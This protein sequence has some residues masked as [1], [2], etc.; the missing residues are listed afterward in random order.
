MKEWFIQIWNM[1][2]MLFLFTLRSLP[3]SCRARELCW[4]MRTRHIQL[5]TTK[6]ENYSACF[7]SIAW[8]LCVSFRSFVLSFA[9]IW[10]NVQ[11]TALYSAFCIYKCAT[12]PYWELNVFSP[13]LR[14]YRRFFSSFGCSV[15]ADKHTNTLLHG[16]TLNALSWQFV[17]FLQFDVL[18]QHV[19]VAMLNRERNTLLT[20][21]LAFLPHI[22]QCF[23][24][25]K[26]DHRWNQWFCIEFNWSNLYS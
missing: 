16:D 2:S 17:A 13:F 5:L 15:G 10:H 26:V 18:W 19:H 7:D 23:T 6:M 25:W 9:R 11:Y 4:C 24:L 8:L 20:Y 21:A 12:R 14:D 1:F 22:G 3:S